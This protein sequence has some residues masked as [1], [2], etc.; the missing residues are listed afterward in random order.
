MDKF[1]R[2]KSRRRDIVK[3]RGSDPIWTGIRKDDEYMEEATTYRFLAAEKPEKK[4]PSACRPSA[5]E[6]MPCGKTKEDYVRNV[7]YSGNS[8]PREFLA[9][10]E[11]RDL[12][13]KLRAEKKAGLA[14]RTA[15]FDEKVVFSL[16]DSSRKLFGQL[17]FAH[18]DTRISAIRRVSEHT[19]EVDLAGFNEAFCHELQ[20]ALICYDKQRAALRRDE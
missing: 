3:D 5:K 18:P 1:K 19:K 15:S 2:E 6:A 9:V 16:S 12:V 4:Q 17:M 7:V 14:A 11:N 8:F 20:R 10:K 13:S